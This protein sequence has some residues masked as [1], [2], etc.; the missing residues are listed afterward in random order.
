MINFVLSFAFFSTVWDAKR[1]IQFKGI[2]HNMINLK[3]D[4]LTFMADS[5]HGERTFKVRF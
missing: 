2:R 4:K 1:Q 3:K 5:N